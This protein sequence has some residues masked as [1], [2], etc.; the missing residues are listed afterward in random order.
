MPTPGDG[1]VLLAVEAAAIDRG[2]WHLMTG[3]PLLVR[4]GF[5]LRGPRQPVP[6]L[7]VVGTVVGTGRGVDGLGVGD[8]VVGVADGSFAEHAVADQAKLALLPEGVD[9]LVAAALPVSGGTALQAVVDHG[10]VAAGQRV[11]V[12]GA[13]GGVGSLAVQVALAHGAVVTGTASTP[14][15]DRV[16]ALGV[17]EV[18]D[19]TAADPLAAAHRYDLIVDTGGRNSLRRLR[20]ALVRGGT[21]VIVGG[22]GGNVL[23]GGFGRQCR[24]AIV[25]PLFRERL[26]PMFAR[27]TR[28]I[29][30][31][32]VGMHVG[33]T[34]TPLVDRVVD[35]D[36]APDGMRALAAGEVA[37]KVVVRVR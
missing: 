3:L 15:L 37:G 29:V 21:L 27:D 6:G 14:K 19:H 13:S 31:R 30:E 1:Q 5:G 2:T 10:R 22:E 34:L 24:A 7:D 25:S 12:L 9:P 23:T 16:R 32:L 17:T 8:R 20:R 18:V 4:L 26:V 35:L 11:L 36:G 28:E 33:G